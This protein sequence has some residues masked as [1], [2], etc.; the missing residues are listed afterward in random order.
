MVNMCSYS[1]VVYFVFFSVFFLVK[2][3][4]LQDLATYII[5]GSSS[6]GNKYDRKG[7]CN[8]RANDGLRPVARATDK[9]KNLKRERKRKR[10]LSLSAA[11]SQQETLA[12]YFT[13]LFSPRDTHSRRAGDSQTG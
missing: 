8:F 10:A 9:V 7:L 11:L 12:H 1:D 4:R 3:Q 6:G 5:L 2:K 13:S